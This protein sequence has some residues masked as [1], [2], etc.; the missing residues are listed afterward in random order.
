M[1]YGRNGLGKISDRAKVSRTLSPT[2]R[3]VQG[4][5]QLNPSEKLG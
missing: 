3:M 1:K 4:P 5:C 2:F